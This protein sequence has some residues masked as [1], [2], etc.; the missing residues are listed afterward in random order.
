MK[1]IAVLGAGI[2][3]LTAAHD[4]IRR[5]LPV[6]VFEA[7]KSVGGMASSFKDAKGFSYDLG[8]HFVSNR[9]AGALGAADICRTVK[10][11]GEAVA[12][13]GRMYSHPFGL[14]R[15]PRFTASAL[16]ARLSP[17]SIE[18]AADWFRGS[19]GDALAEAVAIPLAEA[20][21]G[22][23]A[24]DL[25]P[26]VGNKMQAGVLTS[27]YLKAAAKL[28]GRA[29]CQGYSHERPEGAGVYHVY[30]E[31]G[32]SRLLEPM[33]QAVS[34]AIRLQ[35]PVEKILVAGG[36]TRAVRVAG[37]DID[38]FG[39]DQHRAGARAAQTG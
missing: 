26:A 4:L 25:S 11:Y 6:I 20:W 2:A 30:P 19:Y 21:S 24:D 5:G 17:R 9:L 29:V 34:H 10:R 22:A 18:S 37:Q 7:G 38:V 23:S 8:A 39:R 14:L 35:S 36:R 27:L 31:G 12:V 15:S 28:T 16:K 1:P 13:D 3:G 32:L 33:T